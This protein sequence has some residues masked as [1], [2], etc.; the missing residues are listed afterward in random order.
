MTG[1]QAAELRMVPYGAR[2]TVLPRLA[3]SDDI[4]DLE[5]DAEVSD[6]TETTQDVPGRSIARV[7]T[8]VHLGLGQSILL[9][10]LD[11]ESKRP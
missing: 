3:K 2:L 6:L 4:V 5:V 1:S 10:G 8:L 9:G 11:A 7:K